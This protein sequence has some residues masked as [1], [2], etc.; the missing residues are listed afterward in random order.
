[1]VTIENALP[2]TSTAQTEVTGRTLTALLAKRALI[3]RQLKALA[4]R[5]NAAQRKAEQRAK[6]LLGGAVLS[7]AHRDPALFDRL[8]ALLPQKEQALVQSI[9][10]R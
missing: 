7:I 10:D 3:E 1:M 9:V 4:A 8:L 5:Q 6:F 2:L